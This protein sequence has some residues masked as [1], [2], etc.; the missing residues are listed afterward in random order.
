MLLSRYHTPFG[1]RWAVDGKFLTPGFNL[2]LLMELPAA[3]IPALLENMATSIAASGDLLAPVDP[4]QEIWACGVTYLRSRDARIAES[5]VGDVYQKVYQAERPEL[6]F[7]ATGL[8]A[9]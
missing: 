7:K 8:R 3:G 4:A 5:Q 6:F 1:I 2:S 9:V